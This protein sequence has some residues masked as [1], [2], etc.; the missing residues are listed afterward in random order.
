MDIVLASASPR[1][2]ELLARI[3]PS[4]RIAASG[5][6]ESSVP[7]TDP[8]RFAMTAAEW[9]ARAAGAADPGAIVIGADTVVALDGRIFGKPA[10]RAEARRMLGVLSGRIHRVIT[11]VAF[12]H[13]ASGR[14]AVDREITP[15]TFRILTNEAIE[16]YLDRED[17]ADKAGAYA[18]QDVGDAFVAAIEGDYD[19]VVG[20]PL[21]LVAGMLSRFST[22]PPSAP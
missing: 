17:Y 6:D 21:R 4:F 18:V 5:V 15:V 20:F 1:R 13:A 2:R 7:E 22:S 16:A 11:G 9:K 14:L 3:V 19:N 8:V 12:F 10:G